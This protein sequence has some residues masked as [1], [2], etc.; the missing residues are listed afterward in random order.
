MGNRSRG[1]AQT[2]VNSL[3][4]MLGA[5]G[6]ARADCAIMALPQFVVIALLVQW[7]RPVQAGIVTL[8][9][10]A[11]LLMMRRF[12]ADPLGKALWYSGF[13]VPLYVSGMMASAFAVHSLG[14]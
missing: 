12:S 7:H 6:A 5:D 2:G 14:Y 11:Q 8:L 3:P 1:D 9:L 4:V 10:A 13:G